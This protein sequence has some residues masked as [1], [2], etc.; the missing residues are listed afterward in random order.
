MAG[1]AANTPSRAAEPKASPRTPRPVLLEPR[2]ARC[3]W[4]PARH[5]ALGPRAPR[6][7][8]AWNPAQH[9]APGTPRGTVRSDPALPAARAPGTPQAPRPRGR[10]GPRVPG[11]SSPARNPSG[12]PES[13]PLPPALATARRAPGGPPSRTVCRRDKLR[14]P[15]LRAPS[16]GRAAA[17]P[18]PLEADTSDGKLASM[19]ESDVLGIGDAPQRLTGSEELTPSG[20]PMCVQSV[21]SVSDLPQNEGISIH[22][23]RE[24][25]SKFPLHEAF[26]STVRDLLHGSYLGGCSQNV[27]IHPVHTSHLPLG[28]LCEAHW[29]EVFRD[30]T[31]APQHLTEGFYEV[32]TPEPQNLGCSYV[33]DIY[34]KQDALEQEDPEE[35]S[36]STKNDAFLNECARQSPSSPALVCCDEESWS[37][38]EQSLA[39][40][41]ARESALRPALGQSVPGC[42]ARESA[43][44][45]ALGQSVPGCAARESALRPAPGQSVPGC[46]ARESALHPVRPQSCFYE[47]GGYC[48]VEVAAY[49]TDHFGLHDLRV[50]DKTE[51][52]EVASKE[53]QNPEETPQTPA[54]PQEK[55]TAE[56]LGG[57][58]AV[59]AWPLAG[60]S[61]SGE[62]RRTPDTEQSSESLQPAE[63]DMALNEVLKKL[64]HT[65]RR[66]QVRIQD[67][68]CSNLYLEKK[69]RELQV[70]IA[71][72]QGF[73]DIINK[74]KENI[75][76]LI[77]DKYNLILEKNEANRTLQNLQ[78]VLAN[79]QRHLQESRKEREVLRLEVKKLKVSYIRLQERHL[80]EMQAKHIS[81]NQGTQTDQEEG[82]QK[83]PHPRGTPEKVGS[84]DLDLL[85]RE[86]ET[87]ER[88][89]FYL[90]EEFQKHEEKNLE[91]RQ[92]LKSRLEKLLTH[93]KNVQLVCGS[94]R[95]KNPALQQ[96]VEEV[97]REDAEAEQPVASSQEQNRIPAL[98]M[99]QLKEQLEDVMEADTTKDAGV[100]C[101]HVIL[102]H[103]SAQESLDAP[104]AKRT[105][106][107]P[108]I[109]SLLALMLGLLTCQ[110]FV[111]PHADRLR[112]RARVSDVM[113]QILRSF[114]LKNKS[115]DQELLKHKDKI[116]TL[117][118]IIANEKAF[119]DHA[120]EVTDLDPSGAER[121]RDLPVFLGTT[122]EKH[123]SLNKELDFLITRLG[124]LL[125]SKEDH[126]SRLM[127]ENDKYQRYLGN[128]INKVTSYEEIIQCA[129]QRLQS[130]RSQIALL[131]ERN[132][133][134]EDLVRR[135]RESA[136]KPR[137]T[138]RHRRRHSPVP[139]CSLHGG[140]TVP[141]DSTAPVARPDCSLLQVLD[142]T[143]NVGTSHFHLGIPKLLCHER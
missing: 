105:Q 129:D 23:E 90:Q 64:K 93:V 20:S 17:D 95:T 16:V 107:V 101:S 40:C 114:H 45:P 2:A 141:L 50:N 68:Q 88:E 12:T 108:Q 33:E 70:E 140:Y 82:A 3:A 99:A 73:V 134:L 54:Q 142:L 44:R 28:P 29:A 106:L 8:C 119:Q 138:C 123:H 7:P 124:N 104:D 103:S 74:L 53:T 85:K 71:K 1:D 94:E 135:P 112:E 60:I 27:Q 48:D 110:D 91:E 131:E 58:Q 11:R 55:A 102:P 76:E 133:H 96:Q 39:G 87:P 75:E 37:F 57:A 111:S 136:R 98:H 113:L 120:F 72:Q 116:T 14:R 86:K 143:L 97:Q 115:L 21:S 84:S 121:V 36:I 30:K 77:E 32:E 127:E 38:T 47:D 89:F 42:A 24:N 69:V 128:L 132:K 56:G 81:V 26:Y 19:S 43:L 100:M 139:H 35:T 78:E 117:R 80:T 79:T 61:W 59:P 4:N 109:H 25:E 9:G 41:A 92:K 49:G 62:D 34:I 137:T 65:N 122:R 46:A 118:E 5:G 52:A 63:E 130:S 6:G 15:S 66:Q 83:P 31:I 51:E 126:C 13:P 125:E 10:L 18:P 22:G 67:L